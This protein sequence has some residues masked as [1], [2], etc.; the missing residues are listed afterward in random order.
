[1]VGFLCVR[2]FSSCGGRNA[3][4]L[5]F[6]VS[7]FSACIYAIDIFAFIVIVVVIIVIITTSDP[8]SSAPPPQAPTLLCRKVW[9]P[10]A[11]RRAGRGTQPRQR[12][13]WQVILH[14]PSLARGKVAQAQHT[15][16]LVC[17][18]KNRTTQTLLTIFTRR[19]DKE[20]RTQTRSDRH[21]DESRLADLSKTLEKTQEE[22]LDELAK[23]SKAR[24]RPSQPRTR[25]DTHAVVCLPS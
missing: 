11:Q 6:H 23:L 22:A 15:P 5:P 21:S 18:G 1:L 10:Q 25:L 8:S 12:R 17:G 20:S 24:K 3:L 16:G 7:I 13:R 14:L 4:R 2:I 19:I 9:W